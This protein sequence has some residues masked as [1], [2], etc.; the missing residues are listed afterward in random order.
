MKF[1]ANINHFFVSISDPRPCQNLHKI[2][3][4]DILNILSMVDN[5]WEF[6]EFGHFEVL[7]IISKL[8]IELQDFIHFSCHQTEV[9]VPYFWLLSSKARASTQSRYFCWTFRSFINHKQVGNKKSYM[10]VCMHA[11]VILFVQFLCHQTEVTVP[12]FCLLSSQTCTCN[13][14]MCSF[15]W[16]NTN[17]SYQTTI[18]TKTFMAK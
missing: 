2:I 17:C 15:P 12:Y 8:G 18:Y 9:T 10:H 3:V 14:Q 7:S 16:E 13:Y 4:K 1:A 5:F 11:R 6:N